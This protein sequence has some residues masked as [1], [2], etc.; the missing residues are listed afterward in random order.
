MPLF[1]DGAGLSLTIDSDERA[2]ECTCAFSCIDQGAV[3]RDRE[4]SRTAAFI[5]PEVLEDGSGRASDLK[6][7]RVEGNGEQ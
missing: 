2:I 5:H 1:G 7:L 6:P 4:L 3:A